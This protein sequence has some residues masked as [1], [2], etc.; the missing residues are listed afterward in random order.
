LGFFGAV[1]VL[2]IDKIDKKRQNVNMMT[3]GKSK[4]GIGLLVLFFLLTT[5]VFLLSFIFNAPFVA[6]ASIP[7]AHQ[8]TITFN[9]ADFVASNKNGSLNTFHASINFILNTMI[10]SHA[11]GQNCIVTFGNGT[12]LDIGGSQITFGSGWGA[13]TLD[14]SITSSNPQATVVVENNASVSV[15]ADIKNTSANG[16]AVLNNN[17]STAVVLEGSPTFNSAIRAS[18][19]RLS[20][21]ATFNPNG[22]IYTVDLISYTNGAVLVVGGAQFVGNFKSA[23]ANYA[24][25]INGVNLVVNRLHDIVFIN[26]NAVELKRE[27]FAFGDTV[28]EPSNVTRAAT[29]QHTYTFSGWSPA[30]VA[31]VAGDFTYTATFSQAV[32][33]YTIK[34]VNY[35]DE[36][37]Q[38]AVLPFGA[39]II[40]PLINPTRAATE[41]FTYTFDGW[42]GLT[43]TA[44]VTGDAVFTATFSTGE[45]MGDGNPP[46][47]PDDPFHWIPVL[48]GS[49]ALG[50]I[51]A[52]L[53]L[54]I[55]HKKKGAKA[56]GS[57]A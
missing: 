15:R 10:S 19:G 12:V 43:A 40:P 24:V 46:P 45:G 44:T 48:C 50:G 53:F 16:V 37:L 36:V 2:L 21:G 54:F 5:A 35:N 34:F 22:K 8:Y 27:R 33:S 56:K 47:D 32:N 30:F 41:E 25:R 4:L 18:A 57:V 39:T 29:A 7:D 49:F 38:T 3:K 26:W 20:A 6:E 13:V 42:E 11:G 52:G 55:N 31:T 23:N 28:K 17:S 9:G 1:F 14:G 51:S